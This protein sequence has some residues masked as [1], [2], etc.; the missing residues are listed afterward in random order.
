MKEPSPPT[1]PSQLASQFDGQA[2][3]LHA[4]FARTPLHRY[5]EHTSELTVPADFR[6]APYAELDPGVDHDR[7]DVVALSLDLDE[8]WSPAVAMSALYAQR[9][10]DQPR[11]FVIL[12]SDTEL[13]ALRALSPAGKWRVACGDLTPMAY[14]QVATLT[15]LGAERVQYVGVGYGASV[16]ATALRLGAKKGYFKAGDSGFFEPI[17]H[18]VRD[19]EELRAALRAHYHER[20]CPAVR[21]AGIPAARVTD[22][23]FPAGG[24]FSHHRILQMVDAMNWEGFDSELELILHY[25]HDADMLVAASAE[26]QLVAT[27]AIARWGQRLRHARRGDGAVVDGTRCELAH[28]LVAR[29]LLSRMALQ[30]L[31]A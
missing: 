6:Q 29:G 18:C 7:T 30:G 28:N 24:L 20:E 1:I 22:R 27:N 3:E 21:Q 13:E 26:S 12:P 14:R 5:L 15:Q 23:G 19:P 8:P 25:G 4:A 2:R 10:L 9:L 17:N 31:R 16:G 11:R